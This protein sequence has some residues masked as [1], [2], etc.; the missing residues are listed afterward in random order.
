MLGTMSFSTTGYTWLPLN[1]REYLVDYS[2][3]G[4]PSRTLI[5]D[6]IEPSV[7]VGFPL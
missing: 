2:S 1:E 7:I 4:P 6:P 5:I 3:E